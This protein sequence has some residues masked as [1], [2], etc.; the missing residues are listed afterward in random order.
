MNLKRELEKIQISDLRSICREMGVSFKKGS[1][2]NIIK[3][4]LEPLNKKYKVANQIPEE[5]A[6]KIDS[7]LSDICYE[8]KFYFTPSISKDK[9]SLSFDIEGEYPPN[10]KQELRKYF[11]IALMQHPKLFGYQYNT[12]IKFTG[13]DK[14]TIKFNRVNSIKEIE[15]KILELSQIMLHYYIESRNR[16]GI[17]YTTYPTA[18]DSVYDT[19]HIRS[20]SIYVCKKNTTMKNIFI[21]PTKNKRILIPSL[22]EDKLKMKNK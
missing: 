8:I 11:N 3:R 9:V 10:L 19:P 21:K 2:K 7:Y 16:K 22:L 6:R 12:K 1:K 17:F 13:T 5:T 20:W 15:M 14:I 18:T 4:L